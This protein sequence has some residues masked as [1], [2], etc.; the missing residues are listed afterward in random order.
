MVYFKGGV[1]TDEFLFNFFQFWLVKSK[2]FNLKTCNNGIIHQQPTCSH[3]KKKPSAWSLAGLKMKC[4]YLF[5]KKF[6][7]VLIQCQS[8]KTSAMPTEK[9]LLLLRVMK[10]F[11][12]NLR[13]IIMQQERSFTST[14]SR[15]FPVF[16]EVDV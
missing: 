8:G 10:S 6:R 5:N 3:C 14:H 15:E 4:W 13:S 1:K 16:P 2:P 7:C 12:S 11:P 9:P